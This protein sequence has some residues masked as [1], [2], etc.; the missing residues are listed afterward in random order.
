M[1]QIFQHLGIYSDWVSEAQRQH[2][3]YPL[4]VPGKET[5]ERVREVLGF[6]SLPEQPQDVR[7]ERTWK[8][9]G[10]AGEEISWWVGYGPRTHAYLLKPVEAVQPLPGVIALHD[11]G[12]F[13]YY[14]KEKIAD[15]DHDPHPVIHHF[16]A[17]YYGNRAYA[18]NLAAQG[19]V[20]LV[21]DTFLWGSRKFPLESMPEPVREI[22]RAVMQGWK[23]T[24]ITPVE[25]AEYNQNTYHHEHWIEKYC[26][27]L[28]TTLAG[29]VS[30]E[31]RIAFNYLQSRPDVHPG[32]IGCIG[33]SGGGNRAGLL[34]ATCDNLR[35]A[36]IVGL[37]S[38]YAH[39]L[40]HN[41]GHT[42]MFF[43]HGW[44]RYG[45]WTDLVACR[46]PS[47]LLVQYDLQDQLFTEEGMRAAHARLS[48]HYASAGN[49][50]AYTGEFYPGPHKFDLEMQNSAF[51]W[52]QR[53]LQADQPPIK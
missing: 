8:K 28:G 41:V 21:H 22:S 5:Q 11:H 25:I 17:Q 35:A 20:V 16:R 42:W 13:K 4:A 33:L 7:I 15:D 19:F 10:I 44:S 53:I 23:D 27:L 48:Q 40:D 2:P 29:V 24:D 1:N 47:P 34:Q 32:R 52:L 26:N 37:M 45:D 49:P 51:N 50:S 9:D 43:P 18:N 12:G 39:L 6:C 38:T 3:L 46:A 31:D 30:H 14:G 36:V